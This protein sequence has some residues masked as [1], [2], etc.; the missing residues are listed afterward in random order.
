[1]AYSKKVVLIDNAFNLPI[2][3]AIA[4]TKNLLVAHNGYLILCTQFD[5]FYTNRFLGDMLNGKTENEFLQNLFL[6]GPCDK[7]DQVATVGDFKHKLLKQFLLSG[8]PPTATGYGE[9]IFDDDYLIAFHIFKYIKDSNG[10]PIYKIISDS[11]GIKIQCLIDARN[12]AS[13][14]IS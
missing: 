10:K 4:A 6:Y 14:S 9:S 12:A 8:T 1:M 11:G 7:V 3:G 13:I 5:D 2:T